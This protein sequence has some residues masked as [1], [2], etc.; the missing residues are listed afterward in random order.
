MARFNTASAPLRTVNLA[1]GPAYIQSPELEL[2]S[3]L[4]SSFVKNDYYRKSDDTIAKIV[5]LIPRLTD[6]KFAAKA[7]LYAR[8]TFGMRTATHVVGG[9]IAHMM[10][11]CGWTKGFFERLFRRPDD[12]METWAY[13]MAKYGKRSLPNSLKK[14][15]RA[16]LAGYTAYQIGK[17]KG[18]GREV[19]LRDLVNLTHPTRTPAIQALMTTGISSDTWEVALTQAGHDGETAEETEQFKGAAWKRLL[20]EGKLPYFAL[21]RNI[22]NIAEQAPDCIG[23]LCDQLINREAIT[24]SLVLPFRFVKAFEAIEQSNILHSKALI[25]AL[26]TALDISLKNCPKL[27]GRTC[28][29]LD[30]SGSMQGEPIKIGALFTAVLYK[31]N[32]DADIVSFSGHARYR[33]LNPLDTTMSIARQLEKDYRGASTDFDSIF[34]I[35]KVPYDRIIILSD[36]QAW[37]QP[38]TPA[39]AL[40]AY[41]LSARKRPKVYSWDLKGYGSMQFPESNVFALAGFSEK[42]FDLMAALEEGLDGLVAKIKQVEL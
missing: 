25:I 29:A 34:K 8:N 19:N 12:A 39:G 41:S 5:E 37:V 35:L 42:V 26:T 11:G 27:P 30:E 18:E 16:A 9:E 36:M 32:P 40:G 7:A 3:I 13:Y 1:G 28:I 24:K 15:T 4:L 20:T 22:R 31:S 14:G 21:L 33:Q 10:R 2:I 38:R 6:P 17:Y 23:M